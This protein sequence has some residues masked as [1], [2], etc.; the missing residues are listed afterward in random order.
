MFFF[1]KACKTKMKMNSRPPSGLEST[2]ILQVG[3]TWKVKIYLKIYWNILEF[4]TLLPVGTL[5]HHVTF[6][7]VEVTVM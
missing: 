3:N 6:P 7:Y 5:R 4:N 2:V 1:A